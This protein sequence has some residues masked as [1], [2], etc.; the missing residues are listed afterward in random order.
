MNPRPRRY[1]RSIRSLHHRRG[2][3]FVGERS[4]TDC[5]IRTNFY[6]PKYPPSSPPTN[7]DPGERPA[8]FGV[9]NEEVRAFTTWNL[10]SPLFPDDKGFGEAG[11][12]NPSGAWAREGF[13]KPNV[14]ERQP[15]LPPRES[16]RM[17]PPRAH[18]SAALI[19]S[20]T[21]CEM[22]FI[23]FLRCLRVP[24]TRQGAGV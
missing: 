20:R 2:V 8:R 10:N 7:L 18:G 6:R 24:I 4:R 5:W 15:I 21:N 1:Q 9:A 22:L 13:E 19:S 12:K 14:N 3:R 17:A 16:A 23:V 11:N